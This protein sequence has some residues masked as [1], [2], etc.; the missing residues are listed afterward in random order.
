MMI[1][2]GLFL[3][4][5]AGLV[6]AAHAVDAPELQELQ[7]SYKASLERVIKPVMQ[8]YLS[9][10]ERQR[11]SYTRAAKLPAANAVQAEIDAIKVQLNTAGTVKKQSPVAGKQADP[12]WY[13]GKTW[14]TARG[15]EWSFE[16]DGTG[17]MRRDQVNIGSFTWRVLESGIVELSERAAADAPV[18]LQYTEFKN[19]SEA[20]KGESVE[21]M[22]FRLHPK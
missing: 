22:T 9:D 5:F 20:W 10:L 18:K 21:K 12:S 19:K 17:E 3:V 2:I 4:L 15:T 1:H 11:D 14:Q 7:A 6:S 8:K 13:I 16:K